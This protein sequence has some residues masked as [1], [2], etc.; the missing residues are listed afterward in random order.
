MGT[1]KSGRRLHVHV[2]LPPGVK[3]ITVY[4]PSSAEWESGFR[5]RKVR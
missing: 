5:K 4:E 2:S 3:I 1:T